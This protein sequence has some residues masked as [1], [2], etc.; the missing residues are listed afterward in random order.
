MALIDRSRFGRLPA[1]K[2]AAI[3]LATDAPQQGIKDAC[4]ARILAGGVEQKAAED[5]LPSG[6]GFPLVGGGAGAQ[7]FQPGLSLGDLEPGLLDAFLS[8]G[9]HG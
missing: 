3:G 4:V 9:G 7:S 6:V 5:D 8:G 2:G 1:V